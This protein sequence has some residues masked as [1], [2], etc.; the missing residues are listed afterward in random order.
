M[1]SGGWHKST[2]RIFFAFSWKFF[3]KKFAGSE[4]VRTF[5]S[6][7]G[8]N[9][10]STEKEFFEKTYIKQRSSSTRSECIFYN[11]YLGNWTNRQIIFFKLPEERSETDYV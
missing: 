11:M 6:A 1:V 2:A 9:A 3:R 5:A 8:K 10:V 7:F 4:K